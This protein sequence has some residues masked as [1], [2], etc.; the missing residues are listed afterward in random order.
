MTPGAELYWI[1]LGSGACVVR[2]NGRL[3]EA[4]LARAQRRP[5]A[6]LYHSALQV[7]ARGARYVIEVTPVPDDNGADRGVVGSGP[8]GM[9]TAGRFRVFRYEIRCW[10]DGV[11]PD[12]AAAVGGP[13]RVADGTL[14]ERLLDIVPAVPTPVWGRDEL[15]AGEMWNSNSVV[16]WLLATAGLPMDSLAPPPGGRAPGWDA[17][18]VVA[19]RERS[20]D[21]EYGALTFS[22]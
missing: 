21:M 17:G 15:R 3:Y 9:R 2:F 18:L 10:R 20:A 16:A 13:A 4:V 7:Y 1:P 14:A 8:V 11:I 5:R 19:N 6:D 22:R 12:L